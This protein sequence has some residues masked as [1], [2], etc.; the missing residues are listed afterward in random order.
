MKHHRHAS[1]TA[2]AARS[3]GR[4]LS[5]LLL[6]IVFL[7]TAAAAFAAVARAGTDPDAPPPSI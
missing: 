1:G 2:P 3:T 4:R 6:S 5:A 7:L